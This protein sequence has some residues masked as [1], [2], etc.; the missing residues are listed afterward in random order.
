M[1][2]RIVQQ[3]CDLG[4]GVL[5]VLQQIDDGLIVSVCIRSFR[6]GDILG[7]AAGQQ[8]QRKQQAEQYSQPF[9]HILFS[10]QIACVGMLIGLNNMI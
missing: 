6:F 2:L 7:S 3:L 5:H 10:F 1:D 8:E 9:F 4:F